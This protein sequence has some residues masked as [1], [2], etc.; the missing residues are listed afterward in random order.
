[1]PD[2]VDTGASLVDKS[3][4]DQYLKDLQSSAE[5]RA[6]QESQQKQQ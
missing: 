5:D 4:V 2:F 6:A 1:V 3:N